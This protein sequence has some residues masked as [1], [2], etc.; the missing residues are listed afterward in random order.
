M[1]SLTVPGQGQVGPG[2]Q[3]R[4]SWVW[5]GV[6]GVMVLLLR[7]Y[8][9]GMLIIKQNVSECYFQ[10]SNIS[11]KS[12]FSVYSA[13]HSVLLHQL[14]RRQNIILQPYTSTCK[15]EVDLS[16]LAEIKHSKDDDDDYDRL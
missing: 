2:G 7:A 10:R 14:V 11:T 15:L 6:G 3:R 9:T 4:H 12:L 8:K 1:M 5:R 16:C 13:H